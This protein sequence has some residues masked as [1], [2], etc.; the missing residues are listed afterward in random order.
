M[1]LESS[2]LEG[3]SPGLAQSIQ[4]ATAALGA[5]DLKPSFCEDLDLLS[6]M[7]HLKNFPA[8]ELQSEACVNKF[9]GILARFADQQVRRP[10]G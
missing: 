6:S 1:G 3:R 5:L 9:C 8:S 7:Y 4:E 2:S 10:R